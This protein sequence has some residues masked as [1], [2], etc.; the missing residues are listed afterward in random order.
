MPC[1][2]PASFSE[3]SRPGPRWAAARPGPGTRWPDQVH[4]GVAERGRR[5]GGDQRARCSDQCAAMRVSGVPAP[6]GPAIYGWEAVPSALRRATPARLRGVHA[7]DSAMPP[8]RSG[9]PEDRRRERR[10]RSRGRRTGY[11]PE[12]ITTSLAPCRHAAVDREQLPTGTLM[13]PTASG[14]SMAVATGQQPGQHVAAFELVTRQCPPIGPT[15][16]SDRFGS[17]GRKGRAAGRTRPRT[18]R[19]RARSPRRPA[20]PVARSNARP[21]VAETSPPRTALTADCFAVL[22]AGSRRT[23]YSSSTAG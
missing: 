14:P 1:S 19:P 8:P 20:G 15:Q 2:R 17:W 21:L 3:S 11:E 12:E 7:A 13:A 23:A 16:A 4:H 22:P 5:L 9:R 10:G 18:P 6:P